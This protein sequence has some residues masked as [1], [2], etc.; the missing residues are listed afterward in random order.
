MMGQNVLRGWTSGRS[1][2]E[3]LL[4]Q[5]NGRGRHASALKLGEIIRAFE[6]LQT[7]QETDQVAVDV[8]VSFRPM[9]LDPQK[10]IAHQSASHTK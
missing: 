4:E 1:P 7:G 2:C 6:N 10:E 5:I 3:Q 8:P 9:H